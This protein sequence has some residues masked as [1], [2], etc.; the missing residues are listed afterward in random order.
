MDGTIFERYLTLLTDNPTGVKNQW[1]PSILAWTQFQATE[2]RTEFLA[3]NSS[4]LGHIAVNTFD[5]KMMQ[6]QRGQCWRQVP[7]GTDGILFKT[8]TDFLTPWVPSDP[9]NADGDALKWLCRLG[10]FSDGDLSV[11][12]QRQLLKVWLLH[13]F[14]P[15]VNPVHPIPLFEG[16]TGSGKTVLGEMIGRWLQGPDFDVMGLPTTKAEESLK[17]ALWKRPLMVLDNVDSSPAWLM[18]FLCRYSTGERMSCRKLY[19]NHEE[20]HFTPRAGLILTSRTPHFR[21]ADVGRRLLPVHFK[22][23]SLE[24]RLGE[25][26]MRKDIADRRP[27]IWADV[28]ATLG[29]VQDL[30]PSI[31]GQ[32]KPSHSLS[33]FSIFGAGLCLD[34]DLH[35]WQSLMRRLDRAQARFTSEDD[36]LS[37]VL[38]AMLKDEK[39][40]AIRLKSS[41]LYA[42]AAEKAGALHLPWSYQAAGALTKAVREKQAALEQHLDVRIIVD[43]QHQGGYTWITI[44]PRQVVQGLSTSREA[45]GDG[46]EQGDVENDSSS[47]F[48]LEQLAA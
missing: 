44:E 18:D 45:K 11:D 21:R 33:D 15:A 30:W 4:D 24:Q 7:N 40:G 13:L 46:G 6:R 23:L 12:D 28:L 48:T 34:G 22:G 42:K 10:N 47:N 5:G 8:P 2:A 20:V 31:A 9:R 25:T 35:E 29:K 14:M 3:Y 37:E 41:D 38:Q 43:S 1:R 16:M 27:A 19:T 17:L 39:N 32:V 36:P 26:A